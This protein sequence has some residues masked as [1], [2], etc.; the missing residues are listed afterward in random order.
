MK[1]TLANSKASITKY[2]DRYIASFLINLPAEQ[3]DLKKWFVE[4]KEPDY[5]SYSTAHVAMSSYYIGEKLFS[6][7]VENIG[8]DQIIQHYQMQYEAKDHVFLYSPKSSVYILRFVPVAVGVPWEMQI[9]PVSQ[10]TSEFICM[11]GI[12]YPNWLLKTVFSF[13]GLGG[14]FLKR[15]L[16]KEGIAFAKDIEKKFSKNT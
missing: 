8:I 6:T 10:N 3:I 15:H 1:T 13:Y 14:L 4:M 5:T 11:F 12:D 16:K 9:R 2:A 7:N